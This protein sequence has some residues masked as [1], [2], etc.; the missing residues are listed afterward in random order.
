MPMSKEIRL[1]RFDWAIK[2]ILRNK[3]NF[4]VLEGF[5]QDLLGREIT[6]LEILES[7]GNQESENDKFNRVD[8]LVKDQTG[9][10]IIIEVQNNREVH[11]L[12]RLL[13]G[14]SK[15][16]TESMKRGSLYREVQKVVSV[17]IVYFIL[18]ENLDD[19]LYY[20]KTDF[21][22][23]HSG[24][25][26]ILKRKEEKV[27][28]EVEPADIFPEYWLIEVEKFQNIIENNLDEW[29]YFFKNETIREDFKSESIKKA[30]EKLDFLKLPQEK[31]Q[32]YARYL[33]NLAIEKEVIL[34][35]W[36]DGHEEGW[37]K[38]HEE[39]WE[40]GR[41]EGREEMVVSMLKNGVIPEEISRYTGLPIEKILAI[42]KKHNV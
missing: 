10:K 3:A 18:G 14:S 30:K 41:E 32:S 38:G 13:Y 33:E 6:I 1:I 34:S 8:I 24:S 27:Y 35:A 2:N 12:E 25:K 15:V 42:K 20:G 21:R 22:G 28:K 37:G 26:L 40:G 16:I 29:I 31:Q 23:I 7:E 19:Y 17:S 4:D 5:L 39:G 9:E 36:E 11:Y